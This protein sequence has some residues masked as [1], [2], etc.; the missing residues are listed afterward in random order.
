M[1][2]I[3]E[4]ELRAAVKQALGDR[5]LQQ[6]GLRLC[7][8]L[9]IEHGAARVD[10][11]LIGERLEGYE[12]KSDLDSFARMHNQI[13]AYNRVFDH[14]TLV[15]GPAHAE[16][17]VQLM[18][19][20]WGLVVGERQDPEH[21]ALTV[22][23]P[24]ADN[25]GQDAYSLAMLLWREEALAVLKAQNDTPPTKASRAQLS[26]RLADKFS[27]EELKTQV[28]HYLLSRTEL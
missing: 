13:H 6:P 23:R 21:I 10:I 14:I 20:W 9:G 22:V 12:L 17:A 25:P 8:E 7:E 15:T 3:T 18:P 26:E 2:P 16:A 11:A 5:A 4:A 1:K 19:R 28:S 24:P 27:I